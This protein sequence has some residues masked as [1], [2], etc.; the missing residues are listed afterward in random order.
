MDAI[1]F[2]FGWNI[3]DPGEPGKLTDW[4]SI[5]KFIFAGR[6]WFTLRSLKTGIRYTY[7]VWARKDGKVHFVSLLRGPSNADDFAYMGCILEDGHFTLTTK[8]RM[9]ANAPSMVA[10]EWFYRAM[11]TGG[12]M[13]PALEVWHEGHCGRCG[14]LLTVPESIRLGLGP[15]CLKFI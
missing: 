7:R 10:W 5:R 13:H 4:E 1:C 8:S 15:E 6:A 11:Q 9:K 2:N 14:R 12:P 3:H